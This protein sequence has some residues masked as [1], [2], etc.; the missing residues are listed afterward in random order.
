MIA[1]MHLVPLLTERATLNSVPLLTERATLNVALR[2]SAGTVR[3][4]SP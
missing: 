2:V 4:L 1:L 3:T